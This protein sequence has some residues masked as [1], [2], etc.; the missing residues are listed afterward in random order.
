MDLAAIQ[1]RL[2]IA[3]AIARSEQNRDVRR[4][5][6]SRRAGCAIADGAA[7]QQPHDFIR[8][9]VGRVLHGVGGHEL[10]R[11][12]GVRPFESLR[13]AL[14]RVEGRLKTDATNFG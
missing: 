1:R 13:P 7:R 4:P 5:D 8:D 10:H 3:M 14:S 12:V 2:E 11:I 6:L 9:R